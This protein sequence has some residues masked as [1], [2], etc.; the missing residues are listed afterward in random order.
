LGKPLFPGGGFSLVTLL[1]PLTPA[2]HAINVSSL[3]RCFCDRRWTVISRSGIR[4]VAQMLVLAL[5]QLPIRYT[6][7]TH[8]ETLQPGHS[9]SQKLRLTFGWYLPLNRSRIE[10]GFNGPNSRGEKPAAIWPRLFC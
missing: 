4:L 2:R 10:A 8:Q 6:I 1:Q 9:K 3:G 5:V 7:C